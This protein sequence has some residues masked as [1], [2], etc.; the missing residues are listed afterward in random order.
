MAIQA[1][2]SYASNQN[3]TLLYQTEAPFINGLAKFTNLTI[4]NYSNSIVITYKTLQINGIN[5]LNFIYYPGHSHLP[6][7]I[8][9]ERS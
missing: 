1:N 6:F 5:R 3:V 2:I 7:L 4:S 8:D 9:L